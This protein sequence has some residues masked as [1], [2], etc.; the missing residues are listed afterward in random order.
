MAVYRS[1][2]RRAEPD[3]YTDDNDPSLLRLWHGEALP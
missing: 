2:M 1:T 3:M